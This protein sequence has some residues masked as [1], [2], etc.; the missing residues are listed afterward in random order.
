MD[1]DK[2]SDILTKRDIPDKSSADDLLKAKKLLTA[3]KSRINK[4]AA[5][6]TQVNIPLNTTGYTLRSN[7]TVFFYRPSCI[8]TSQLS[9]YLYVYLL[10]PDKIEKDPIKANSI[11]RLRGN[12]KLIVAETANDFCY[13]IEKGVEPSVPE[14]T[15]RIYNDPIIINPNYD[16]IP[17]KTLKSF[18]TVLGK[19]AEYSNTEI[20]A[21][22]NLE[23]SKTINLMDINKSY[24]N[25]SNP[26]DTKSN[27]RKKDM[28][29][30]WII[31][32]VSNTL[33]SEDEWVQDTVNNIEYAE[34]ILQNDELLIY[35]DNNK[36]DLVL[37]QSGT[38]IRIEAPSGNNIKEYA[39]NWTC[40]ALSLEEI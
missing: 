4:V 11:Y 15:C 2:T 25:I 30:A 9:T 14:G 3:D 6:T 16:I 17:N 21:E 38:K 22:F 31:N 32:N 39:D 33:F 27:W 18:I 29:A 23:S 37:L 10:D 26:D 40:S 13:M 5:I 28:Y 19:T 36:S 34:H 8:T 20:A 1:D 7:E 24:I 35:T 12:Q